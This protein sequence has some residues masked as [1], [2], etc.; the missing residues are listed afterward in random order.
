MYWLQQN[1]DLIFLDR[2]THSF[3]RDKYKFQILSDIWYCDKHRKAALYIQQETLHSQLVSKSSFVAR[4]WNNTAQ[5]Q[6][7]LPFSTL[8]YLPESS[9]ANY[10]QVLGAKLLFLTNWS[11]SV[12]R[13][14]Y[15]AAFRCLSQYQMSL[16]IWI[17][18][19]SLPKECVC[20]SKMIKSRFCWSLYMF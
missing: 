7:V 10:S 15:K 14:M 6:Q 20:P 18:Y 4:N 3:G 11:G 2:H 5:K 1:L 19:L 17:L 16:K 8:I 13:E 12:S 9:G